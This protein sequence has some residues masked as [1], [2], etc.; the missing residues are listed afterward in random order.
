MA[1]LH[2]YSPPKT[3]PSE[4]SHLA[5]DSAEPDA[6]GTTSSDPAASEP[7]VSEDDSL[8]LPQKTSATT[9]KADSVSPEPAA[10]SAS[11][12]S[13]PQTH[14]SS[15]SK[16]PQEATQAGHSKEVAVPKTPEQVPKSEKK[17]KKKKRAPQAT[18]TTEIQPAPLS[19]A[20]AAAAAKR[21]AEEAEW[22]TD[23]E[24][25]D[26]EEDGSWLVDA[27]GKSGILLGIGAGIAAVIALGFFS[28]SSRTTRSRR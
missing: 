10:P 28:S 21:K 5:N 4:S 14:D 12:D 19:A 8:Q 18:S 2:H 1:R 22:Y 11:D 15:A 23:D 7:A 27:V 20:A 6:R 9:G 16:Q 24:G 13:S 17:P 26:E 25:D 3:A